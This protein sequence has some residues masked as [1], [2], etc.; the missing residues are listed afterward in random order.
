MLLLQIY[1]AF[2]TLSDWF[3]TLSRIR[4]SFLLSSSPV[5]KCLCANLLILY[6]VLALHPFDLG[7]QMTFFNF[8][9]LSLCLS[10]GLVLYNGIKQFLK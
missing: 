5:P 10:R 3:K 8:Q 2:R 6:P 9:A 7:F 4:V 1:P